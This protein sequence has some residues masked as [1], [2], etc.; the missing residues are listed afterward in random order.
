MTNCSE[1]VI[2]LEHVSMR[3]NM[4]RERVDSIKE[5]MV[6]L[7]KRQLFYDE[8]WALKDVSFSVDRGEVL[9]LVGLNGAGKSTL[10]KLVAGV[11]K[12][13]EGTV[14][15]TGSIA[16]L[17][18]LGAGFDADLTAKENVY[19][20]GAVLG[21]DKDYMSQRYD[22][23][24]DFAE[25]WDFA[26]VPVKNFSSGMYARLGFAIATLVKPEI[27]IVDEILGVGDFRFQEKCK[28]RIN[29]LMGGGTTVL[30][31]S[32][33]SDTIKQFCHRAVWL[34]GGTV[35]SIGPAE[36]ICDRYEGK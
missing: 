34:E 29:E 26:D 27:L 33:S 5:Y 4:S 11:L 19:M 13:T 31:V 3:F 21:Y 17:I 14:S 20:N 30:M 22:E 12:P 1:A 8:F 7:M 16:P 9:G 18:E 25:L 32:H 23:I 2:R 10:L 24:M 35:K 15:V 36:E 6:R 28:G